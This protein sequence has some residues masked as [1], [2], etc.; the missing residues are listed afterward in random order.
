MQ[1]K[2]QEK[3]SLTQRPQ[4]QPKLADKPRRGR[5]P[6]QSLNADTKALL[7]RSGLE[8][9]TEYGFTASGIDRVLKRAGVPKG[10]FYYYFSSKE[11]FGKE[12]I[13][14]YDTFFAKKLD[15]YLLDESYPPL[16]RLER[17]VLD[18]QKT[19]EKYSF[20]RGCLIGNLGQEV[21]S[22][23]EGYREILVDVFFGWQQRVEACLHLAQERSQLS[24]NTDCKQLAEYF[25]IGWEGAVSRA[26]LTKSV[27]PLTCFYTYFMAAYLTTDQ[28]KPKSN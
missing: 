9:L 18:A 15:T 1:P 23:P 6:K 24:T 4:K 27:K 2:V 14:S 8:H 13:A 7:I 28:A 3:T 25:W 26:K 20:R 19:M 21:D 12:L 10:S 22:L 5:P 11:A 16:E 17:Y